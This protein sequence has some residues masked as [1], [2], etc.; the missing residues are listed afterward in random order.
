M[1]PPPHQR[2][3][4]QYGGGGEAPVDR[5]AHSQIALLGPAVSAQHVGDRAL[6]PAPGNA[7]HVAAALDRSIA[8]LGRARR[9][10][11]GDLAWCA[12]G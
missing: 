6:C 9:R 2:F 10:V 8:D 7:E 3:G 12:E 11:R 5:L 1:R 4:T